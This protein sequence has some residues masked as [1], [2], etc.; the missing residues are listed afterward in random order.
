M[1]YQDEIMMYV[2]QYQLSFRNFDYWID[3]N[4]C[5]KKKRQKPLKSLRIKK[6]DK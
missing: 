2:E 5:Y 1:E 3:E 6:F 4:D